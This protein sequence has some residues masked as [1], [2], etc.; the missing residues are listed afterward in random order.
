MPTIKIRKAAAEDCARI[1]ELVNELAVYER[2]PDEVTVTLE[3][4]IERF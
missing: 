4:F 3:H 1:L 2:A